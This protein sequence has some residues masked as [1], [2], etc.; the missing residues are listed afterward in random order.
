MNAQ[1]LHTAHLAVLLLTQRNL[2]RG[3]SLHL[4]TISTLTGVANESWMDSFG[5]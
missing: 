2:F 5:F 4:N 1:T 3:V